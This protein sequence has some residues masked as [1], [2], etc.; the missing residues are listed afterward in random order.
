M[1]KN[2]LQGS[3]K[4]IEA[5]LFRQLLFA[6]PLLLVATG[7][8][9]PVAAARQTTEAWARE[10]AGTGL[11]ISRAAR[12]WE[13]LTS[14][15]QR[16]GIF[17][18]ETGRIEGWV[19]PLKIFR[20]FH[21]RFH[22][23]GKIIPAES[24]ARQVIARPESTTILYTGDTFSVRETICVPVHEAGAIVL[25]QVESEEPLEIEAA[26]HRDFQLEWPAS[27][28][29][30]YV[31]WDKPANAFYFGEEQ[32]NFS[33]F[34]GSPSATAA[35]TEYQTNYSSTDENSFRLGASGKGPDTKIIVLAASVQGRAEA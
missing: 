15:G 7:V 19:Y 2:I 31:Y 22:T 5:T 24:L 35:L 8:W 29:A 25:L 21:L 23:D 28:G 12:P 6:V 16:A 4:K 9:A 20:D 34:L 26:F 18:N 27:L 1:N 3:R 13:F 17:G 11:E 14:V 32:K 33:A 10:E 30:T